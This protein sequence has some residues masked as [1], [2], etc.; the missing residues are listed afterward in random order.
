MFGIAIGCGIAVA[1]DLLETVVRGLLVLL[2]LLLFLSSAERDDD[3]DDDET[4]GACVSW[5]VD[6]AAILALPMDVV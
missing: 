3:D 1:D 2:L 5:M 4:D 6:A